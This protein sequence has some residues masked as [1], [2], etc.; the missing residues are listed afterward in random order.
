MGLISMKSSHT[1]WIN[2]TLK[3]GKW[4]SATRL[5]ISICASWLSSAASTMHHNLHQLFGSSWLA[6][7]GWCNLIWAGAI[8]HHRS[9]GVTFIYFPALATA[10]DFPPCFLSNGSTL[11]ARVPKRLLCSFTPP[12]EPHQLPPPPTT[13]P[14]E[15]LFQSLR[16]WAVRMAQHL[17]RSQALTP[18]RHAFAKRQYTAAL[19]REG[20]EARREDVFAPPPLAEEKQWLTSSLIANV[21]WLAL[22][23]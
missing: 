2:D 23:G 14:H 9:L 19:I 17:I 6:P 21:S 12:A 15:L 11:Q 20:V 4:V 7:S 22:K 5:L 16:E 13:T 1:G 3:E 10:P 8:K 18:H